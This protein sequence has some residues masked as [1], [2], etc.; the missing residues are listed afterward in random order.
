[1][2]NTQRVLRC[3]RVLLVR[4]VFSQRVCNIQI[5]VY[6]ANIYVYN[7]LHSATLGNCSH[8]QYISKLRL[9]VIWIGVKARINVTFYDKLFITSITK[10]YLLSPLRIILNVVK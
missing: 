4:E 10:K 7:A 6:F 9:R 8:V 5:H 1:M 3:G 2:I